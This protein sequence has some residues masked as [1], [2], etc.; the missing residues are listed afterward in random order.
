MSLE[1][2]CLL[3]T[4]SAHTPREEQDIGG[5][6]SDPISCGPKH[7]RRKKW[8][9]LG[10]LQQGCAVA[11]LLFWRVFQRDN[12]TVFLRWCKL[13]GFGASVWPDILTPKAYLN[14]LNV[15][16]HALDPNC[17]HGAVCVAAHSATRI[18]GYKTACGKEKA[19]AKLGGE[20]LGGG[21][22]TKVQIVPALIVP[23]W[24]YF[25]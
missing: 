5:P 15:H 24:F 13:A 17:R 3:R 9:T 1:E 23:V 7:L 16:H 14:I 6:S 18:R 21:R 22:C 8:D 25:L 2:L 10:Q 20:A 12:K 11:L 19:R 4:D